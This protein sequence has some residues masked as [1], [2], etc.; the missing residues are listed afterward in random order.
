MFRLVHGLTDRHIAKALVLH[1]CQRVDIWNEAARAE[2]RLSP[3]DSVMVMDYAPGVTL[4]QWRKQF[5]GRIVPLDQALDIA[6]QIASAL[7]Y[8][9][10]ERIVHR[11][12]KPGNI[13]VE[14]LTTN[15]GEPPNPRL[16]V[17]ILDFGLAAEIRSSMSR[18][19][20]ETGDT[21][22]TRPYMA[23]EQWLGRKQDGRTDQYAL[24][25]VLYELLSGAPPFA[26]VFETGDPAI[27]ERAVVGR[28][29]DEIENVP[30]S[31]NAALLRALSKS[32][33][34][35]FPSCGAFVEAVASPPNSESRTP[36]QTPPSENRIPQGEMAR[37]TNAPQE[38]AP[39]SSMSEAGLV[40]RKLALARAVKDLEER[41]KVER[42]LQDH[43]AKKA[44]RR[45][46][47]VVAC[48]LGLIG[49]ACLFWS[50][51]Q[52]GRDP[53]RDAVEQLV[54]DMVA[55]PGQ[56]YSMGKYEVTQAQWE[57]VM[58]TNPSIFKGAADRPVDNV[59]WND[60]QDFLKKLNALPSVRD[61]GLTFRL[62]T[63]GEW[64]KACRAG[65]LES[66]DYCKLADG[67]Q[68]TA[69]TLSKVARY[70]KGLGVT[71]RYYKGLGVGT[72]PVGSF[73]PNAWGLYDMHGNVS[74]WTD[75]AVGD[76]H[77]FC[78]GS[79]D[80]SARYCTVGSHFH[81]SQDVRSSL[82]GFRLCASGRTATV[83]HSPEASVRPGEGERAER[84]AAASR[85]ADG[86]ENRRQ[87]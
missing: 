58:G 12:I 3:G 44:G 21:S 6:R 10:G 14:T 43:K 83:P 62:P 33:K 46:R 87:P 82:L 7:D 9:H 22:G 13:M 36:A 19:S 75:T 65:A 40:R 71:A 52:A 55:I 24:A 47:W 16:R 42:A 45:W 4:S 76:S 53:V 81:F 25:C 57:A 34:D 27:M 29:P 84:S 31:V 67:T 26:G 63:V 17:R 64:E 1:P 66:A 5:P 60:C 69:S 39:D 8:A 28:M 15:G 49:L 80:N 35:R 61:S 30:P 77:V 70:D 72:A 85:S 48:L 78:G 38:G 59:S 50:W 51:N 20:S 11:D 56:N 86:G 2:M 32:P 54:R 37:S 18:V 68:I 23:P 41:K 74:E 79:F 73:Q